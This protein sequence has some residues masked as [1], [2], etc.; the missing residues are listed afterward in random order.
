MENGN[1]IIEKIKTFEDACKYL[2][3][4]KHPLVDQYYA[5]KSSH[6]VHTKKADDLEAYLKLR[7]I[8]AALNEGV[9]PKFT[10]GEERYGVRFWL[11][12]TGV[13]E[14]GDKDRIIFSNKEDG[15]NLCVGV[16]TTKFKNV[17]L[18]SSFQISHRLCF[19]DSDLA[20]YCAK[21]FKEIWKDYL[22][23]ESWEVK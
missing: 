9:E 6:L 7:I 23:G 13:K 8:C 4:I 5:Y 14:N 16:R 15:S 11:S 10:D 18:A 2:G 12:D 17:P 3:D 1:S 21:Q 22:V 19:T 20:Y